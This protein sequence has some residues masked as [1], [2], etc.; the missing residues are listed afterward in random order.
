MKTKIYLYTII[1]PAISSLYSGV[2]C[3]FGAGTNKFRGKT[4]QDAQPP[5]EE[6]FDPRSSLIEIKIN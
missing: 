1:S 6:I 4:F 5:H 2:Q 3:I